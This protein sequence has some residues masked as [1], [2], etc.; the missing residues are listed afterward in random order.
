MLR[1]SSQW[2]IHNKFN[3]AL[4]K[5]L[6]WHAENQSILTALHIALLGTTVYVVNHQL[7]EMIVHRFISHINELRLKDMERIVWV[8]AVF[9]FKS[10]TGASIK[11]LEAIV[12]ELPKRFAEIHKY[13]Q[14]YIMCTYYLA[15]R[16]FANTNLI[17]YCLTPAHLDKVYGKIWYYPRELLFLD[18]Y[19]RINLKNVYAGH[20]LNIAQRKILT[21]RLRNEAAEGE[22]NNIAKLEANVVASVRKLYTYFIL[23]HAL[24]HY[25]NTGNITC[26]LLKIIFGSFWNKIL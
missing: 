16:G 5:K 2:N 25:A 12:N 6:F 8:L 10:T 22:L 14:S 7:I 17:A 19:T 3:A 18:S 9:D 1:V 4:Q 13:T 23:G 11:L 21:E 24:P 20:Q 15:L 26:C